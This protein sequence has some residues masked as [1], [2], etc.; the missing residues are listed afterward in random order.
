MAKGLPVLVVLAGLT[1]AG[2]QAPDPQ[3]RLR[4]ALPLARQHDEKA[5]GVLIELLAELPAAQS[6][7]AEQALQDLAGEWAPVLTL[8]RDDEVSRRIRRDAWAA[9][10]RNTDGP[11][12]LAAFRRRTLSAA[13]A[14]EVRALIAQ[15]GHKVYAKREAAAAA[16]VARGPAV[17]PLLR[18]ALRRADLEQTRRIGQC[19]T[20]IAASPDQKTLP[21][22]AA[23]LLALRKP[24]GAEEALLGYLP[25]TDDA[26][27]QWEV[28]QA[29]RSL[30]ARHAT[31]PAALVSALSDREPRRRAAAAE[32]LAPVGKEEVRTAVRKLLADPEPAV[33]LR[34][35]VA[36]GCTADRQA[37]PVLIELVGELPPG[38]RWQAEEILHRLAGAAAPPPKPGAGAAAREPDREA[39]RAW[40]KEHAATARLTPSPVPPPLLGFTVI[41]ALSDNR[42]ASRVYEVDAQGK[43]RWQID[44]VNY[45]VDAQIL[46]GERVLISEYGA[47]RVTER[48]L[49]GNILW[50]K[51]DLPAVP[52]NVQ[53]LANGNTFV[54]TRA[55]LM[56]F[57]RAG[58]TVLDLRIDE[59][60]A[61]CKLPDGQMIYLTV[62]GQ[63]VR[64]DAE[65]KPVKR[66]VSGQD[67][68]T[69]CVIDLTPAGRILVGQVARSTLEEF[70]LEGKSLWRITAP[71]ARAGTAVRNGHVLSANFDGGELA[72]LDRAGKAVWQYRPPGGFRPF[73]ARRR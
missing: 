20:R 35:A 55:G 31:P 3:A 58:K 7:P 72:E 54:C 21:P 37:V 24:A 16:L 67:A 59:P 57:D 40:W 63:C 43:V 14:D 11:A 66:F 6:R 71:P 22:V 38:Q 69:G 19:L 15:L 65:G 44:G 5:I 33:R 56:E 46:P 10:W 42:A 9:W 13:Q 73:L 61:G 8:A 70:D 53:R 29:L 26:L 48:D 52:Y 64:L 36:L 60:L 32:I 68:S 49:R 4:A 17:A 62:K 47:R 45:P 23:R 2:A 30:A 34:A 39:W 51:G 28:V 27:M 18:E 41:V 12:L 1:V 25:F 50:E